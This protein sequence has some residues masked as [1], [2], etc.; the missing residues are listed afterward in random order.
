MSVI[1][2]KARNK[3]AGPVARNPKGS[4]FA[5]ALLCYSSLVWTHHTA[6][7]VPRSASR[8]DRCATMDII[9]T[10]S[11]INNILFCLLFPFNK[12]NETDAAQRG[13]IV[14]VIA[15]DDHREVLMS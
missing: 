2:R 13:P 14:V 10:V 12:R 7:L 4:A 15:P 11:S 3:A 8:K 1:I 5:G 9:E 6:L